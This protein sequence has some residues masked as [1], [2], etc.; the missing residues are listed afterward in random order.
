MK[1]RREKGE[2]EKEK[3]REREE[4]REG[5]GKRDEGERGG[6]GKGVDGCF[7]LLL[8]F[9]VRWKIVK[10]DGIFVIRTNERLLRFG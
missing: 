1:R 3:E 8:L 7:W 4:E 2:G 5:E 9:Y 6:K 10:G